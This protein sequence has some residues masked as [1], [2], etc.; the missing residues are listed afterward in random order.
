[1]NDYGWQMFWATPKEG[2]ALE[3]AEQLLRDQIEKVKTGDFDESLLKGI[4]ANLKKGRKQG[5][6]SDTGRVAMLRNSF[7]SGMPWSH[8]VAQ[9]ERMSKL[10]KDDVVRAANQYFGPGYAVAYR[11]EGE[12]NVPEITKPRIDTVE[13]D[14]TRQ[15]AFA[16]NLLAMPVEPIEPT[17]VVQGKDYTVTNYAEGVRL[18]H[19]PNPINDLFNL[20]FVIETGTRHDKA[21]GMAS[22]LI[23]QAGTQNFSPDELKKAWFAIGTDFS[24]NASPD[25]TTVSIS[26]LDENLGASLSLLMEV[27]AGPTAEQ[28]T[29][30]DMVENFITQRQQ[31]KKSHR[32]IASAVR[33]LARYGED[34]N[35]INVLSNDE[36]RGLEADEL[37]DKCSSLL[38]YKHTIRYTGSLSADQITSKL[39]SYHPAD[40]ELKDT[41][42]YVPREVRVPE[43]VEVRFHDKVTA[44][45]MV[46]LDTP[47]VIYDEALIPGSS[48]YN[49]YFGGMSG[50]AFQELRESRALA[51]SVGAYYANASRTGERN[52]LVG[53]IG[54]QVDKTIEALSGLLELIDDMPVSEE[55]FEQGREALVNSYR[56]SKIGFRGVISSVDGWNKLGLTEDPRPARLQAIR[57]ANITTLTDFFEDEI[58]GRPKYIT[59]VG[60]KAKID[61]E[62][63]KQHGDFTEVSLEE[64][65]AY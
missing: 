16:Q 34:S 12:R 9:L 60:D 28:Q 45:A 52:Q 6:E 17:Y 44:Q 55:R 32:T 3:E 26:G 35:F 49:Q 40:D 59:V 62:L 20:T 7:L 10:T 46:Y 48:Y 25:R 63:L 5:L 29:L 61:M 51:Y 1:M 30:A 36:L 24:F 2:Q 41:P 31:D 53:M 57:N 54:C 64:L 18:Y 58:K 11:V 27:L 14:P 47:S 50:L 43:S 22:R 8:S 65:F 4:I 21:L 42:S 56:T 15:S 13:I 19:A 38:D 37:L 39:R 23:N 33:E